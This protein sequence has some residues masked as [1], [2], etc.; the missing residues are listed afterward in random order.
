V[1]GRHVTTAVTLLVLLAILAVA[2]LV[3][4]KSLFAPV[5]DN[6]K[7]SPS[8]TSTTV[9]KG[10]RVTA[11]QVQVSV[12]NAGDRRG[13]ADR[14]LLA[15]AHRGFKKG[16]VGNAPSDAHVKRVQVWTT[17]P[18]DVAARLVARQFGPGTKVRLID[19]NLGPGVDVVVGNHRGPLAKQT[20]KTRRIVVEKRSS[21][22][23]PRS[24]AH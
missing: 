3:G 15:L 18:K 22:C 11:H 4:I 16:S 19:T 8:C 9:R 14:T 21:A 2:G 10:Q 20:P 7:T 1:L 23:L 5:D 12:F 24:S 13:L 6:A 17:Q